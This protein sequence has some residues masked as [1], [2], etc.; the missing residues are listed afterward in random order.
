ML[1]RHALT[2]CSVPVPMLLYS[3]PFCDFLKATMH[4]FLFISDG[5]PVLT[6]NFTVLHHA[7]HILVVQF[8][9]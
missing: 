8:C 2:C 3:Y 4:H 9:I 6:V 5:S 1:L 7:S